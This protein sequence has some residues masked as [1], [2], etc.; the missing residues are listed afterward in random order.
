MHGTTECTFPRITTE[1]VFTNTITQD[2]VI[3]KIIALTQVDSHQSDDTGAVLRYGWKRVK[4]WV[5]V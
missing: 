2:S 5:T 3:M 1:V 4:V